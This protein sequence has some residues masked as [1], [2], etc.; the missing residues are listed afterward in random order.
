MKYS[1]KQS[2][3]VVSVFL[4]SLIIGI[5]VCNRVFLN[6]PYGVEPIVSGDIE[7]P[8]YF[9][10]MIIA[11]TVVFLFLMKK[12]FNKFIRI[13]FYFVLLFSVSV[14]LSP[15]AGDILAVFVSLSLLAMYFEKDMYLNNFIHLLAFAGV[16][17]V[18][19]LSFNLLSIVI[20]LSIVSVYDIVSV[21][22]TKHMLILAKSQNKL[23]IFAGI[24]IPMK[25][26]FAFLGGG[27]IVFPTIF[28]HQI[29]RFF[30]M[31]SLVL[32]LVGAV[33]GLFILIYLGKEKK[34]Y[35]AIP[36]IF[37]GALFGFLISF[38]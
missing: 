20:L 31:Y 37:S 21:F 9:F 10:L 1:W 18:I 14:A 16:S 24:A 8:V 28:L 7:M 17:A 27:D 6:V 38:F 3:V 36:T 15:F 34:V 25:K 5:A 22:I 13:W 29:F 33:F 23:G 19:S 11:V 2:L 26:K 35:P 4:V 32:A 12:K 30:G